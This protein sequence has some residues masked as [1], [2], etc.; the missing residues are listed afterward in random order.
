M[1]E[2]M[3]ALELHERLVSGQRGR[4]TPAELITAATGHAALGWPDAG[5]LAPGAPAD[6]VAVR[7]DPQ[8]AGAPEQILLA[9]AAA[10]VDTVL[11]DGRPVVS[12][13]RHRLGDVGRLL[14]DAIR[15]LWSA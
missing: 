5:R 8:T 13:G 11:V 3:R 12:G 1:F 15:P 14:G 2:E 6:L 4:F 9:A 10:D 7:L